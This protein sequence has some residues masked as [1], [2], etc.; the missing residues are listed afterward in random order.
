LVVNPQIKKVANRYQKSRR[1]IAVASAPRAALSGL[2]VSLVA[3]AP[4]A[5]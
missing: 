1:R 3:A 5:P 4:V 2:R